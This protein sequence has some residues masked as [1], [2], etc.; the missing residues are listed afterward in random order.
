MDFDDLFKAVESH[1][2]DQQFRRKVMLFQ[3]LD[4][5]LRPLLEN[6]EEIKPRTDEEF[7]AYK[8]FLE[9]ARTILAEMKPYFPPNTFYTL[10]GRIN[11]YEDRM[12]AEMRTDL[13]KS[14][15]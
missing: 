14:E 4:N 10:N 5:A 6:L 15:E 12:A 2:D 3:R 8:T 1:L 11:I 13:D 9:A 7:S